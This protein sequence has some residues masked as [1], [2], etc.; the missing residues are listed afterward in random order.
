ME[1]LD[2]HTAR[3]L[4]E[5]QL[6]LG[7]DECIGDVPVD[8]YRLPE[9]RIK[10]DQPQ[11]KPHLAKGP[12]KLEP[13]DAVAVAQAAAQAADT[14]E[15]LRAAMTEFALCDLKRGAR[16][17]VFSDGIAGAPVMI[18]GDAPGKKEDRVGR[19]FVG[20]AGQLLDRMLAAIEMGRDRADAPVY[21]TNALP[22]CPPQAR[23]PKSDEIAMMKPFL[24]RHIELANPKV[25]VL[26]GNWACQALLAKSGITRLR[27]QWHEAAGRPALP[28][29]HPADL[30]RKAD[31]KREAWADLLSLNSTLKR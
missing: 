21:I 26:M 6:E 16:H 25:L 30:L 7:A 23:D 13:R 17:M 3:A 18:I 5:W 1:S 28:M 12:V 24:M 20:A 14:L 27:G 22:W 19:L 8:C 15:A 10:P 2:H 4:L 11:A 29:V 9:K 31:A